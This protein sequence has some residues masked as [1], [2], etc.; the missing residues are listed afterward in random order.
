MAGPCA[1][2]GASC[3]TRSPRSPSSSGRSSSDSRGS[4]RLCG[5][6]GAARAWVRPWVDER[7]APP[8]P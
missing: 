1:C 2:C 3:C 5:P 8:P 7:N 6:T 4:C